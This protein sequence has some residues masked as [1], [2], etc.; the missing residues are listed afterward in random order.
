[1]KRVTRRSL[2][3]AFTLAACLPLVAS[4]QDWYHDR[5]DR[6]RGE[7]WR[8]HIF[9]QVREDLDHIYTRYASDKERH[10][11]ERTREE[12]TEMQVELDHGQ[13]DNGHLNDV[14]DSLGKSANDNRLPL[15]D[16]AILQDDMNR[17]HD[18]QANHNHW[19]R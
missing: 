3:A 6:Y 13:F 19:I 4:P 5:D 8:P 14:I 1:M 18:Y 15:R 11:L 12:L 9:L 2:A 10:R 16:R 7:G 17:L